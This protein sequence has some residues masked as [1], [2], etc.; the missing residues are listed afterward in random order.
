MAA[1][2]ILLI[3]MYSIS[4]LAIIL[5]FIALLT[6][7]VYI[8]PTTSKPTEM[9]IPFFGKVKT[10][11][12]ALVF[13]FLGFAMAFVAVD[14]SF[15]PPTEKWEIKGSFRLPE[16]ANIQNF[17]WRAGTLTIHPAGDPPVITPEGTFIIEADIDIGKT[18]EEMYELIDY[19]HPRVS[20][21]ILLKEEYQKY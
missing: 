10:N 11:Y 13:T 12:P 7:R 8:D 17:D 6:Q 1:T 20:G 19:S 16:E 21:E 14:K 15:P 9:S 3:F 4:V 18:V 5:G 2:L